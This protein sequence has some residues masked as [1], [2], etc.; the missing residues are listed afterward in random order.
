ME[1][2]KTE[3]SKICSRRKFREEIEGKMKNGKQAETKI[4]RGAEIYAEKLDIS[5]FLFLLFLKSFCVAYVSRFAKSECMGGQPTFLDSRWQC[6]LCLCQ[7]HLAAGGIY[8]LACGRPVDRSPRKRKNSYPRRTAACLNASNCVP[9]R[10]GG[11]KSFGGA[12]VENTRWRVTPKRVC[13]D[14]SIAHVT[15]QTNPGRL[16][17]FSETSTPHCVGALGLDGCRKCIG[18]KVALPAARE[19]IFHPSIILH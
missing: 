19:M 6:H 15:A 3:T 12:S 18:Q 17:T 13:I 11:H 8:Y 14:L 10:S 9:R 4:K 16:F 7:I 5:V 1:I 2:T